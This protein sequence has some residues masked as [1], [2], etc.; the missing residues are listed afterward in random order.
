MPLRSIP[1]LGVQ[2]LETAVADAEKG[3]HRVVQVVG[4]LAGSWWL[5]VEKPAAAA[6]KRAEQTPV[7]ESR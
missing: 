5:L 1:G 3:G 2:E 7:K 4:N 6:R